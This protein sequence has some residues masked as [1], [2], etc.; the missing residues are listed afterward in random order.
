MQHEHG[1][2]LIVLLDEPGLSLHGKAQY[3][4]LRFMR[5]EL[6]TKFQV[7]YTTHS[8]FMIGANNLLSCRTVEDV[9]SNYEE[10]L[11]TKVGDDVLS[12][13]SDT[14]FPLQAALGY[15]IT[16]SMFIGEHC[17][18]VE[19]PSDL[20]YLQWASSELICLGRKGLDKRWTITPCGGIAKVFS[21]M[22]LFGGNKLHVAV[23]TDYGMGDKK[24]V[25]EL[26]K[27]DLLRSGHVLTADRY[28]DN[29]NEADIE[30]ILGRSFYIELVNSA[31]ALTDKHKIPSVP[32]AGIS[33]CVTEEV[34]LHFMNLPPS[35]PEYDHFTPANYL[36]EN[37]DQISTTEVDAALGRF[38]KLFADINAL[39]PVGY[40]WQ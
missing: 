31:Y 20:L 4:L 22:S 12:T 3:D 13:D 32:T 23:L 33:E 29:T 9:V 28:C 34:K 25:E 21:F 24:K 27:S 39:L 30:D 5:E 14:L 11:G 35:V 6:M 19:G 18:L 2:N 16:Q 8:P 17:L 40:S 37:P 7:I 10:I 15:D 1:D 36:L 38:E 26:R